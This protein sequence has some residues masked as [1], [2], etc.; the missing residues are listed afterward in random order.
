MAQPKGFGFVELAE[1]ENLQRAGY[2]ASPSLR[3]VNAWIRTPGHLWQFDHLAS[4]VEPPLFGLRSAEMQ[5]VSEVLQFAVVI[6]WSGS[7]SLEP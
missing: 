7:F 5:R 3:G 4:S 6:E 2:R 1:G